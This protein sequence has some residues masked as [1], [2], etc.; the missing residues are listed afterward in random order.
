[1]PR[2]RSLLAAKVVAF[3]RFCARWYVASRTWLG[4]TVLFLRLCLF[5]SVEQKK[6]L[7]IRAFLEVEAQEVVASY[8]GVFPPDYPYTP[9]PPFKIEWL[10][11]IDLP[12]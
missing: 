10:R 1:M 2:Q 5:V 4:R 11:T 9:R 3:K 7:H 12:P 8:C 6:V